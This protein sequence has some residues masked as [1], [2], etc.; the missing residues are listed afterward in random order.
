MGIGRRTLSHALIARDSFYLIVYKFICEAVG[1]I[2]GLH[3]RKLVVAWWLVEN[4][5]TLV[6]TWPR[7]LLIPSFVVWTSNQIYP[8]IC[9]R[10][11]SRLGIFIAALNRN[12]SSLP[13]CLTRT[14]KVIL[15]WND[16]KYNSKINQDKGMIDLKIQVG[17]NFHKLNQSQGAIQ[18]VVLVTVSDLKYL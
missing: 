9:L 6:E 4:K 17:V 15:P 8:R 11:K 3:F 2:A 12:K 10:H 7:A 13:L 1:I 5:G 14:F 16:L 18:E